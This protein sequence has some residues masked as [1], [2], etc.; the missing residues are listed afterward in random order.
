MALI[1]YYGGSRDGTTYPWDERSSIK[2]TNEK[3]EFQEIYDVLFSGF[4]TAR[5]DKLYVAWSSDKPRLTSDEF[6]AMLHAT[7]R[8]N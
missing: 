6:V 3:T 4:V 7:I 5:G 8:E 2:V 1:L